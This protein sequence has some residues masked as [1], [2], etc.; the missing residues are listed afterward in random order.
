M[1]DQAEKVQETAPLKEA[2][3]PRPEGLVLRYKDLSN[4]GFHEALE[5]IRTADYKDGG[6]MGYLVKKMCKEVSRVRDIINKEYK[7]EVL[8]PFA[9]RDES[10]K[11]N[12]ESFKVIPEKKEEFKKVIEAFEAREVVL[13]RPKLFLQELKA[14]G[15][16]AADQEALETIID[17]SFFEKMDAKKPMGAPTIQ[18]A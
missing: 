18:R 3:T 10:G 15:L 13:E 2:P 7:A 8:E 4:Y 12:E 1:N 9:V 16:S 5:K 11:Y 14:A 17:D 6:R